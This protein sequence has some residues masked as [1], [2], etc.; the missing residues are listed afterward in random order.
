MG[1]WKRKWSVLLGFIGFRAIWGLNWG[2]LGQWNNDYYLGFI[3][4]GGCIGIM[5]KKMETIILFRV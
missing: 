1:T 5:E 3:L 4:Y 2:K